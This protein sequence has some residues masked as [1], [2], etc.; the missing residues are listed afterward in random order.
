METPS[1]RA[2]ISGS[3]S[4][5]TI[6]PQRNVIASSQT[7][8]FRNGFGQYLSSGMFSDLLLVHLKQE[9]HVHQ[10]FFVALKQNRKDN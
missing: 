5:V 2:T 4:S 6:L 8:L 9:Y 7:H 10:V 1:H 3:S